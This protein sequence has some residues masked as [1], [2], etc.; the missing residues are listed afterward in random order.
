PWNAN[1]EQPPTKKGRKGTKGNGKGKDGKGAKKLKEGSDRTPDGKPICVRYNAKGCKNG[2][3]CHFAHVCMLCFGKHP[4]SECTQQTAKEPLPAPLVPTPEA[5]TAAAAMGDARHGGLSPAAGGGLVRQSYLDR[6]A[7]KD[8]G[9]FA[10][11]SAHVAALVGAAAFLAM[12]Q[13]EDL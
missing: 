2:A 11:M 4:A 1:T 5:T 8:L 7:A 6:I 13:P 9:Q 12:G 3:K 10:A